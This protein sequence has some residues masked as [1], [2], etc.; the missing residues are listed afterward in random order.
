MT[1]SVDEAS[2]KLDR[3]YQ[4]A[5]RKFSKPGAPRGQ[6]AGGCPSSPQVGVK[7]IDPRLVDY[8][9]EVVFSIAAAPPS[10]GLGGKEPSLDTAPGLVF[11]L[12]DFR[13][14]ADRVAYSEDLL[15]RAVSLLEGMAR[16]RVCG[17]NNTTFTVRQ[18]RSSDEAPTMMIY[19]G[20][21]QHRTN[22]TAE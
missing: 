12:P 14:A 10:Q 2:A 8:V 16:C 6:L 9:Y 19:C 3:V 7:K 4:E 15:T 17:S 5:I 11:S 1:T 18:T 21:C 13:A 22:Q 20:S